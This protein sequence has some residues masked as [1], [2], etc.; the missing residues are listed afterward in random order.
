MLIGELRWY[1]SEMSGEMGLR[2]NFMSVVNKLSGFYGAND[3]NSNIDG[4]LLA[5]AGRAKKVARGLKAL[6]E[7]QQSTLLHYCNGH[8]ID[9]M[10]P[11]ML[12]SQLA[13]TI[14]KDSKSRRQFE[15]WLLK[16][17]P[18]PGCDETDKRTRTWLKLKAE[19]QRNLDRAIASFKLSYGM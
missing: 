9:P 5:A 15:E 6:S 2:S 12:K 16:L 18:K 13:Y 11:I 14:W 10:L 4:R 1:Y 17:V 19:A 8:S 3:P 7:E